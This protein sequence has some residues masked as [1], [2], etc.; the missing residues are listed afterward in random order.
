MG[1]LPARRPSSGSLRWQACA[2]LAYCPQDRKR[3]CATLPTHHHL[4]RHHS[5]SHGLPFSSRVHSKRTLPRCSPTVAIVLLTL[6]TPHT[7]NA[8][9][10]KSSLDE[11]SEDAGVRESVPLRVV[12]EIQRPSELDF[13]RDAMSNDMR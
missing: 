10:K 7:A 12:A 6:L 13:S 2:A 8:G 1:V 3:I 5:G 9:R 4:A 11:T